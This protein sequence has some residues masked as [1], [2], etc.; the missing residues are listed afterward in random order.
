MPIDFPLQLLQFSLLSK[1]VFLSKLLS[2]AVCFASLWAP[3]PL[4][5][6]GRS[7]PTGR[8]AFFPFFAP[9]KVSQVFSQ[10]SA[11]KPTANPKTQDRPRPAQTGPDR[12]RPAQTSPDRRRP[13][14]KPTTTPKTQDRPRRP[15]HPPPMGS[16]GNRTA[17]AFL[18]APGRS[19]EIRRSKV[20]PTE[21]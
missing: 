11:Q 21:E 17:H 1:S 3:P 18:C 7:R 10:K 12:P 5:P 19:G 15:R 16:F 13:A 14:Q 2:Q 8:P 4:S 6:F 20:A 9:Q